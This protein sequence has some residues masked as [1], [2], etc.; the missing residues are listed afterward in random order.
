MYDRNLYTDRHVLIRN[1]D[2]ELVNKLIKK[3]PE[4]KNF[5]DA[6]KMLISNFKEKEE[7]QK[8]I[9]KQQRV[10]IKLQAMSKE[11]SR[12]TE[13][14]GEL[15]FIN[16]VDQI[17]HGASKTLEESAEKLVDKKIKNAQEHVAGNS[18]DKREDED[19]GVPY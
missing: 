9:Q 12:L 17:K 2:L 13:I 6:L 8:E 7:L 4:V 10:E 16:S 11:L 14:C 19:Y 3:T 15:L 5:S 1:E 18:F